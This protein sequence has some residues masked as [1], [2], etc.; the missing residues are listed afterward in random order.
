MFQEKLKQCLCKILGRQTEC[1]MGDVEMA[2]KG[3]IILKKCSFSY[4]KSVTEK[5]QCYFPQNAL[6]FCRNY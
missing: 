4:F 6:Q 2:N 1:I 3:N 5:R